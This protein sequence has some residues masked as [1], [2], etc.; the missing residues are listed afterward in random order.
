MDVSLEGKL[1][2]T[3]VFTHANNMCPAD[4]PIQE[5]TKFL[6]KHTT[7][8]IIVVIDTHSLENGRFVYTGDT[9]GTYEAC[10]LFEVCTQLTTKRSLL[11]L[12]ILTDNQGLHSGSG[13]KISSSQGR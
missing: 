7:A 5:V 8:K 11:L 9:P 13:H 1:E 3:K 4:D 6:G 12:T 10:S 2:Q